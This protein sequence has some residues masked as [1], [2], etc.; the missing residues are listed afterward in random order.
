VV[1]TANISQRL[2]KPASPR[3]IQQ[4]LETLKV[5]ENVV[6]TFQEIRQHLADNGVDIEKTPLT[7]GPWIAIDSDKEKFIDNP[8][9]DALLTR[10]YRKPF[11]VP[12]E[13]EV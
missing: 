11:V 2:G 10:D 5:N 3:E 8:A 12:G 7:L 13:N 1:H 4:A 6:E 9:A